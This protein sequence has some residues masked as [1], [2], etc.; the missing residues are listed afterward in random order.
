MSTPNKHST[1][2]KLAQIKPNTSRMGRPSDPVKETA[3]LQAA[4][5]AFLELP[6]ERVS[7]DAVATRA[8]VSKVTIYS[9]Y[10]SKEGLFVAAMNESC[11]AIYN[12]AKA[13]TETG[14]TI[15]HVLTQLGT[16]FMLMILAPEVAA[17][18][19]VM[20]QVAQNKPDLPRQYFETVVTTS[21]ETLAQTL[22]IATKRGE[23][24]CHDPKRA[25]IQ[26]I[27]MVQGVYRYELELG[28]ERARHEDDVRAY[29]SDCVGL[30]VRGYQP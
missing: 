16:G 10:K 20:M 19:G 5:S 3:I 23:L 26:F 29:V 7:M 11:A 30:F 8:G 15:E 28:V 14:G 27:A 18:H 2:Q 21:L 9:K 24:N 4:R 22:A 13:E 1:Q 17:L 6:Y 25:A 12:K